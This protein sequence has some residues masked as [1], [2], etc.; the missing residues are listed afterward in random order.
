[1]G[2]V[3]SVALGL[4]VAWQAVQRIRADQRR[5]IPI[6]WPKTLLTLAGVAVV[7]LAAIGAMFAA[8]TQ[9]Q[10]VI[11]VLLFVV[12]FAAGVTALVVAVNRRWPPAK[13]P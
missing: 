5:G 13:A 8:L 11:A 3:A 4:L 2:W 1:M 10:P 7:T 6:N 12:A 9:D